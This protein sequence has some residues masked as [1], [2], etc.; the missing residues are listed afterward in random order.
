MPS[1]A[2]SASSTDTSRAQRHGGAPGRQTSRRGE[3]KVRVPATICITL[4]AGRLLQ[5]SCSAMMRRS[6]QILRRVASSSW[7][8]LEMWLCTGYLRLTP[9]GQRLPQT[10]WPP[11]ARCDPRGLRQ[12]R[13]GPLSRRSAHCLLKHCRQHS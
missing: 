7:P 4:R 1:T 11:R 10:C 13:S 12:K 2:C 8:G 3:I 6:A 9:G 5:A